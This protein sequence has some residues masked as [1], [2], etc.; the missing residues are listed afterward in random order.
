MKLCEYCENAIIGK[1]GS[2]RFCSSP[3]AKG[4]STREKRK[5]INNM[6]SQKLSTGIK[7]YEIKCK[8]CES[9][10]NTKNKKAKFC[11]IICFSSSLEIKELLSKKR[12]ESIKSGI[13]NGNGIKS[14][15]IFKGITIKCD[16]NIE[17]ACLNYFENLGA[18]NIKR[19][20]IVIEYVYNGIKK[21]FL[22]D[23]EIELYNKKY[24]VEAKGVMTI[25]SIN[26]KW[27]DYNEIGEIKKKSL[28][29]Y[30]LYNNM[31]PFWFTK[32]INIEYYRNLAR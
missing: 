15:Y 3:C 19:S 27:R 25:K 8:N 1:Y 12:V 26:E 30:C 16:S 24:L 2:G 17:R 9:I 6:V 31:E 29:K 22:P 7:L 23:F 5:E 11:N 18:S 14:D 13:V 28:M 4:Y 32:D 21:R 10:F 20:K